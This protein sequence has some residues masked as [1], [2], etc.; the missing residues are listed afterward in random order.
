[1]SDTLFGA[2]IGVGSAAIG[3]LIAGIL[4]YCS[5]KKL[6]QKTHENDLEITQITEFNKG[7][8]ELRASFAPQLAYLRG[9][10]GSIEDTGKIRD[11]LY[12]D[13]ISIHAAELQKF[14]FYIKSKDI[15]DYD[16]AC[17]KY[18]EQLHPGFIVKPKDQEP[19][20]YFIAEIEKLFDFT[21]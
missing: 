17:E 21:K 16:K 1:M 20:E 10:E 3:A 18:E 5:G 15:E 6:I 2:F 12:S 8:S 9:Y 7:A 4:A 11:K 14:R 13:L 19:S